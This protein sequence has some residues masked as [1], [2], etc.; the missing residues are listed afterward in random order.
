MSASV[1]LLLL[2]I[3]PIELKIKK[4]GCS[5]DL[6]PHSFNNRTIELSNRRALALTTVQNVDAAAIIKFLRQTADETDNLTFTSDELDYHVKDQEQA[7]DHGISMGDL[8]IK[9]TEQD[10]L[11]AI[12]SIRRKS[13]RPQLRHAAEL[14]LV[15]RK[16]HWRLGIGRK[17]LEQALAWAKAA[18]FHKIDLLVI[19]DNHAAIALY[20]SL[21]FETEGIL[22][23]A[24]RVRGIF[25]KFL[26]MSRRLND[27]I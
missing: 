24:V 15:I 8:F 17:I 12:C 23:D 3:K 6:M 14:S 18:G 13:I 1:L 25:K 2:L 26:L 11:V 27:S 5:A 21:G 19:D 22:T 20:R 7:I 16:S 9:A 10:S 4:N